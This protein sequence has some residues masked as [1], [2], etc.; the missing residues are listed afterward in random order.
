MVMSYLVKQVAFISP[1]YQHNV[2]LQSS[3]LTVIGVVGRSSV[4]YRALRY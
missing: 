2:W 3:S 1:R 4:R